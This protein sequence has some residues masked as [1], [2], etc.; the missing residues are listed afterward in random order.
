MVDKYG[1]PNQS[2][3][4]CTRETKLL[5]IQKYAKH[6]FNTNKY[7]TAIG[8]R[9]DEIDRMNDKFKENRIIY[10][11]IKKDMKPMSKPMINDVGKGENGGGERREGVFRCELAR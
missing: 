5:P 10:P 1:I 2:Y 8:I 3:P 9:V 11:L 7:Y 4:H 6:I